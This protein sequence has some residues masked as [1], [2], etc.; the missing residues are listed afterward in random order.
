MRTCNRNWPIVLLA[1]IGLKGPLAQG[2]TSFSCGIG[3][4]AAKQSSQSATL[5]IAL[6]CYSQM[7]PLTRLGAQWQIL[8]QAGWAFKKFNH[9]IVAHHEDK[10]LNGPISTVELPQNFTW[11]DLETK[12]FPQLLNYRKNAN[13]P[14]V[15]A[16]AMRGHWLALTAVEARESVFRQIGFFHARPAHLQSYFATPINIPTTTLFWPQ[17]FDF[18][19]L[20]RGC[21]SRCSQFLEGKILR[22]LLM[23]LGHPDLAAAFFAENKIPFKFGCEKAVISTQ[24]IEYFLTQDAKLGLPRLAGQNLYF[25]RHQSIK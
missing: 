9:Q 18:Y 2:Q 23:S 25:G 10:T 15:T 1:L 4:I 13:E 3:Q 24:V 6:D 8:R 16:E 17:L 5:E 19:S 20:F 14:L 12:I 7:T 21:P 11:T 22:T